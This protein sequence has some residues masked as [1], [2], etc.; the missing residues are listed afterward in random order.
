MQYI[1]IILPRGKGSHFM[2]LLKEE[3]AFG[4]TCFY[5]EGVA[6]NEILSKLHIDKTKR[7]L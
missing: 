4:I 1:I 7:K 6:P 5:G 2:K 3:G